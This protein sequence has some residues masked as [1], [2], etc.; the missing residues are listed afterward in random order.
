MEAVMLVLS[1]RVGE[2]LVIGDDIRVTVVAINRDTVRIGIEAPP[3]I[4]VDRQEIHERRLRERLLGLNG[5][6]TAARHA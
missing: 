5:A 6:A 3:S 4:R 1:R 2:H